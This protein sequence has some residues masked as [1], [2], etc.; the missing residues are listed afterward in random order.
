MILGFLTVALAL[1]ALEAIKMARAALPGEEMTPAGIRQNTSVYV[2]M[3]D[4]TEIAVTVWLP[5]DLKRGERVPVLMRETRY[6]RAPKVEWALRAL[7]AANLVDAKGLEDKQRA[8]FNTRHFAVI[9]V[10]ARGSGAAGGHRVMEYSPAEIA[11]LGEIAAWASTQPWSSGRVG[12]F[13]E[14]YDGN[15]AELP[16]A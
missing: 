15:T 8:Y 11:D 9:L 16:A 10:D 6:W 2:R 7:V 5:R 1:G 13:G 12:T 3:R 4:G 14:S